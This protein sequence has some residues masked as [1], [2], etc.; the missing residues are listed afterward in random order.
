MERVSPNRGPMTVFVF[1][2]DPKR[3]GDRR[4][5]PWLAPQQRVGNPTGAHSTTPNQY[6]GGKGGRQWFGLELADTL[7]RWADPNCSGF[8]QDPVGFW[9]VGSG[10]P[11]A[12]RLGFEHPED[13]GQIQVP[14]WSETMRAGADATSGSSGAGLP[15][16]WKWSGAST[17][18]TPESGPGLRGFGG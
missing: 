16:F 14:A 5:P 17:P 6:H 18:P 9:R 13:F 1:R 11:P 8:G 3:C 2:L 4:I 12:A 10:P 15:C 7:R